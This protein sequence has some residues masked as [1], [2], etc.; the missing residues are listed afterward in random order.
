MLFKGSQTTGLNKILTTPPGTDTAKEITE[1]DELFAAL[2]DRNKLHF[3]QASETTLAQPPYSDILPPFDSS[4]TEQEI[5][6]GNSSSLPTLNP[7][8]FNK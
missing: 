8:S 1:I 2:L 5:L 3:H 6:Q 4:S 7:N